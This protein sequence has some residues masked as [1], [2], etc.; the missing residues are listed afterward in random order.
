MSNFNVTYN[1][2][3]VTPSYYSSGYADGSLFNAIAAKTPQVQAPTSS[4]YW[5]QVMQAQ[6]NLFKGWNGFC[7]TEFGRT[8]IVCGQ[9]NQPSAP[10]HNGCL[11]FGGNSL[12][13]WFDSAA[14][15]RPYTP[16][17]GAAGLP[18]AYSQPG[19]YVGGGFLGAGSGSF[20]G[21]L[22][23]GN[24]YGSGY[25]TGYGN[26]SLGGAFGNSGYDWG[27]FSSTY[28]NISN[29]AF[30]GLSSGSW[31]ATD[32]SSAFGNFSLGK[33]NT[34]AGITGALSLLF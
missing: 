26:N 30:G 20:F 14:S 15:G 16:F 32:Y 19:S 27:N 8:K 18:D 5:N 23:N 29:G 7:G 9:P 31:G 33:M 4:N 12:Q 6:Q 13:H 17:M 2:F 3:H 22:G 25:G 34:W 10:S 21:G 1:G 28:N 24:G 11:P